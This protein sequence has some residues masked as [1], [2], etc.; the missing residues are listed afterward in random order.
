[1]AEDRYANILSGE[2]QTPTANT[3]AFQEFTTG[4]GLQ[5]KQGMIIDQLDY[6]PSTTSVT[7]MTA[8]GDTINYGFTVSNGVTTLEDFTDRRIIHS[9]KLVRTDFGTA[10][11]AQ[12]LS[13]P[14]SYQFF[15]PLVIA[16]PRIYLAA[17]SVG[18]ANANLLRA[19]MYFRFIELTD[20][21]IL[22][23]AQSFTL[24]G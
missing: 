2:I 13:M 23:I 1:M 20:R 18:L 11:A 6:F 21:N 7:E 5:S 3:I 8:V 12:L 24:I 10:A 15:P 4:V 22:E 14:L 9:A 19:R 16:E 17:A